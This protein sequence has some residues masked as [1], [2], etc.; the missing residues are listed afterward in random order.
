[1]N[2]CSHVTSLQRT[3]V[4]ML[5]LAIKMRYF[6]CYLGSAYIIGLTFLQSLLFEYTRTN[7][8]RGEESRH[9]T[10]KIRGVKQK[11][12]QFCGSSPQTKSVSGSGWELCA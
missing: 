7:P 11:Q 10:Q 3:I 4:W 9:N 1:M 6:S 12:H 2:L 5:M 8:L